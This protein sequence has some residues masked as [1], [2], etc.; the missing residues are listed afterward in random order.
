M[1]S[2]M[3]FSATTRVIGSRVA[4]RSFSSEVAVNEVARV[5]RGKVSGEE[6]ALN[7]DAVLHSAL[8]KLQEQPGFVKVSRQLCK[9]EWGK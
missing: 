2:A 4:T 6:S 7:A 9:T 3:R 8:P 1:L 5:I